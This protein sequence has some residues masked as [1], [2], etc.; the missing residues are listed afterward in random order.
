MGQEPGRDRPRERR[1][2]PIIAARAAN[3]APPRPHAPRSGPHQVPTKAPRTHLRAARADGHASLE[4]RRPPPRRVGPCF[5][6]FRLSLSLSRVTRVSGALLP[7]A[8]PRIR[9]R[10]AK[11]P[12]RRRRSRRL[13]RRAGSGS[14][15]LPCGEVRD[16]SLTSP[17]LL[18]SYPPSLL[19]ADWD[20]RLGIV[21]ARSCR[22][23]LPASG[24]WISR[25]RLAPPDPGPRVCRMAC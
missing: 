19:P 11:L 1:G 6:P 14:P 24:R 9:R 13:L 4:A 21:G 18:A 7:P 22:V 3:R 15:A 10:A 2:E 12:L 25:V 8:S 5:P 20:G 17:R 16:H 23:R